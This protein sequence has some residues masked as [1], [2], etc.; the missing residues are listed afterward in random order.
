MHNAI[1]VAVVD[2][3][4]QTAHVALRLLLCE[5]LVLLLADLFKEGH[6]RN[7]LHDEVDELFVVVGLVVIDDIR[8]VELAQD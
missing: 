4:E 8:V 3:L 5:Q 6:S 7:I 2:C 1:R